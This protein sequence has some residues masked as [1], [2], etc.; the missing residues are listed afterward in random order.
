[1]ENSKKTVSKEMQ[2][3]MIGVLTA[4][5][6]V[7]KRLASRLSNLDEKEDKTFDERVKT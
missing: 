1:M 3:E 2:D 7:S 4:I 5:S 6:I